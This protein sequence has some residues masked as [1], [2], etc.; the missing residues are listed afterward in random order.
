MKKVL[1]ILLAG[2]MTAT[3]LA[4]CGGSSES[5][6]SSQGSGSAASGGSVAADG[7]VDASMF[8]S[9]TDITLKV[10]APDKGV[11][12]AKEQV[13]KFKKMYPDV[14]FKKIDVVA[15]GE[16]DAATQIV[17]DPNKAADVFSFPSD[18]F[19][20]LDDAEA[21]AP[22]ATALK[23]SVS[24][25]NDP[26]T[27]DAATMDGKLFA[28]P[29]TN[30]NG[31]YLVYD[32]RVVTDENAKTLEGV[33]KA[34]K[35]NK[36]E[37][38]MDCGNG[39]YSCTFAFTAGA[40][41]DGF[42]EDGETQ[43]FKEYD[44]DEAVETLM[45]FARLMKEY[46]GT[47]KS[48][49]PAQITSGFQNGT[50]GAGVDGS[51]NS[52]ADEDA[53]GENYGVSALPTINVNGKDKQLISMFGYKYIGVN[54]KTKFPRSAQ[55]L[56]NYLAGEECQI[57]RAKQL[58]WGPSNLKAQEDEAVKSSATLQAIA[59][60]SKNAVAQV[61]IQGTFWQAMGTLGSE[62]LKDGWDPENKDATKKLLKGTIKDVRDE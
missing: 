12:L 27:V 30:D 47:F 7:K 33:L 38:I 34:C 35:D 45:A 36:K 14:K 3:A 23:D 19:N 46:K 32:K 52:K 21:L 39:Y 40:I 18:Q 28:Y 48:L 50:L 26:K 49:D 10:W 13:E 9:E 22:V 57:E 59:A 24:K 5:T 4:G 62:M 20:K 58:G 51:W 29:E 15:Q 41:I 54:A 25:N 17:N 53:L 44:E 56:A 60:Q 2:M 11:K 43:K 1:A 42:E 16:N 8:G 61:N 6:A 37:F 55:I 31:Y